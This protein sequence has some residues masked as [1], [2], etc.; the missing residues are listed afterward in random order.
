MVMLTRWPSYIP[1][2][3]YA[4]T[5]DAASSRKTNTRSQTPGIFPVPGARG[6]ADLEGIS[7]RPARRQ[8]HRRDHPH[9]GQ[10]DTHISTYHS[11]HHSAAENCADAVAD[12]ISPH[13]R[14]VR[15]YLRHAPPDDLRLARQILR[16]SRDG[17]RHSQTSIHYCRTY[18]LAAYA[19][20]GAY[21]DQGMDSPSRRQALANAASADLLQR[22]CRCYSL[23]LAGESRPAPSLDL[24]RYSSRIAGLQSIGVGYLQILIPAGG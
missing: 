22:H 12:T 20:S 11:K 14:P 7:L 21:I 6:R 2:W 3:T 13:A 1:A 15:V 4:R 10:M 5:S 19:S 18:G 24:W 9:H 23:Y 17:A 8:P 16:R